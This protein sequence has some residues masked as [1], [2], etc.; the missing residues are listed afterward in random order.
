MPH[1]PTRIGGVNP[2][3]DG[4]LIDYRQHFVLADFHGDCI[5][6]TVGHQAAGGAMT[7][8]TEA[9]GIVDDDQVCATALDEL[10]ADAGAGA[11]GD[12]G[13]ALLELGAQPL[14][15]FLAGVGISFS[16]PGVGHGFV[17]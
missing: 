5:G 12:N 2:A 7:G 11:G 6:V 3:N 1:P 9:S 15:D 17:K 4:N 16:G 8:H 14:D 10:G 13:P